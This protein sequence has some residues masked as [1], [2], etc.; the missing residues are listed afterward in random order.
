MCFSL[1]RSTFWY[2]LTYLWTREYCADT[3]GRE[4]T[5][6]PVQ[7]LVRLHLANVLL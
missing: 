5:F 4:A 6:L 3:A 2:R 7:R 1:K